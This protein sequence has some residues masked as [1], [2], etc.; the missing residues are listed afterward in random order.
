MTIRQ[1]YR[2]LSTDIGPCPS[3]KKYIKIITRATSILSYK[4]G[5]IR[6]Q[7]T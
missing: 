3:M 1:Y 4:T 2:F 6:L 5:L 7:I